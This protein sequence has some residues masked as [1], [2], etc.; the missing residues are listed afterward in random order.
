MVF[1]STLIEGKPLSNDTLTK[2]EKLYGFDKENENVKGYWHMLASK[3]KYEPDF[4]KAMKFVQE[5]AQEQP[6]EVAPLLISL[7]SWENKKQQI[8]RMISTWEY[9]NDLLKI[10]KLYSY[11]KEK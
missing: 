9:D 5:M 3:N 2:M 10:V 11:D 7:L 6:Y 1:L 4:D 8:S